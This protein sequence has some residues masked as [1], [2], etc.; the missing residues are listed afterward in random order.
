MQVQLHRG[1]LAEMGY[2]ARIVDLADPVAG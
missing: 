2:P 1:R